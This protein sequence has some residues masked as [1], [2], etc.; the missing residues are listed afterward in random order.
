M[1]NRSPSSSFSPR[2]LSRFSMSF[3]ALAFVGAV[4][5]APPG[6]DVETVSQAGISYNGI[7][8]NGISYNGIS[9][10]GISYNGATSQD[11]AN[12]F[13]LA[14]GGNVAMHDMTMKYVIR[15]AL[16]AGR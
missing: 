4:G 16:S 9:I 1:A 12:W 7:S 11:F 13:N 10:N 15:C 2:M 5:C 8:Y 6:E 3:C 14:D